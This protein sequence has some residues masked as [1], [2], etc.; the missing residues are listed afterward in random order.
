M[1]KDTGQRL[2]RFIG[3]NEHTFRDAGASPTL[4]PDGLLAFRADDTL[5]VIDVQGSGLSARAAWPKWGKDLR[6]T[7]QQ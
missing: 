2:W 6:N 3:D 5:F 4:L 7:S 1:H